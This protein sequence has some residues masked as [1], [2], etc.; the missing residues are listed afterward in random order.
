MLGLSMSAL[1]QGRANTAALAAK[2]RSVIFLYQFGGPSHV[3]TFDMK[4]EAADGLRSHFR[5]IATKVPGTI[6][7][8]HLP[9]MAQVMDR[10][11][12]VRSVHHTMKNHN[13][14]SYYALTGRAPPV[15]D[16][17]L[18]ESL[19][20]FPA[21]GSVVEHVAPARQGL[22]TFVAEPYLIR[23]GSITPGQGGSFLGPGFDPLLITGDPNADAFQ[24]PEFSLPEG[25]DPA[26]LA[27]RRE[28][29][30][31]I[32]SQARLLDRSAHVQGLEACYERA[33][34]LI[35]STE[36]RQAFE[37]SAESE[38]TRLAYGR[39]TYGQSCLLARRLVEAGV[40]FVN[41]YFSGSIGG[42]TTTG[43]GWDT[44]GFGNTRM[45]PILTANH[46]PLTNQTLPVLLNDLEQRGLLDETLVVWMGEFG[47]TPKLNENIS[48]DHWP[49]CYTVLLAG[50][51]IRGGAIH[52][53]SDADGA[54]PIADPVRPDD[55][56]ATMFWL[57]GIDPAT[58]IHDRLNRPWPIAAG[59]PISS[60]V[61]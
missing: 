33:Y 51:G 50:G 61:G 11:A 54:F 20:L 1:A 13:P 21:Y 25:I 55:L 59:Q 45:Y 41:V 8:E 60:L 44:H 57:L 27:D 53:A 48:R 56:A 23:D 6:V 17:R 37:L 49:H 12:L 7:C 26:R 30:A 39:T 18:P 29:Q 24:P 36:V 46:L 34:G 22:A 40:K 38:A 14:A 42:Q 9:E 4:P 19:D 3:D 10:V 2:A 28:M 32:D 58:E 15:D 43:G 5:P 35:N 47:R 52:G 31:L 16:I